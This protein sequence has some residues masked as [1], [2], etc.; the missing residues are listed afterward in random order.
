LTSLSFRFVDEDAP[1]AAWRDIVRHGWP[2]W[3][4]WFVARHGSDAPGLHVCR[5]ALRRHL[6]TYE[7]L[8]NKLLDEAGVDDAALSRFLT[9]WKPPRYLVNCTQLA[10]SD[11]DG[12]LLIRNYD[13]DPRLNES[14]VFRSGWKGQQVIGMVEALA[15]LSDGMN[16]HGLAASLTFGGRVTNG[17]GFGIPLV[18][19]YVLQTCRDVEDG[20]SLLR[21]LPVH[22]SYN[23]TLIDAAG[24][25]ATVM[26]SPDRPAIVSQQPW[27]TNHQL[28]VE[29]PR[30][31]RMTKTVERA[32]RLDHILANGTPDADAL[33]RTFLSKPIFSNRYSKG[34]GTVFTT[35]YR[36]T[37]RRMEIGWGDGT[38][39]GWDFE[40][41]PPSALKVTYSSSG[42]AVTRSGAPVAA[43]A[44]ETAA[45]W[46]EFAGPWVNFADPWK[47]LGSDALRA[48]ECTGADSDQIKLTNELNTS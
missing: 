30:H 19:R 6:P 8:L 32:E 39:V 1:G 28:G 10:V 36:P 5:R 3:R 23:V 43:P 2:G 37:E 9:F 41:S 22:M 48:R 40:S 15:G 14:T 33:K 45:A 35:L 44:P 46:K 4:D 12:P 26:L 31:G 7:A 11:A 29:W 34:F 24:D 17:D 42:S 27:A 20:L 21:D 16:A 47:T 38:F 13:L 18:I 25:V